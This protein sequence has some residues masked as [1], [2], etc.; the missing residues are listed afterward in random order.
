MQ[1]K[2]I[3][4]QKKNKKVPAGRQEK[5]DKVTDDPDNAELPYQNNV[6]T[7]GEEIINNNII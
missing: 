5:P 3:R 1:N 7:K 4:H 2:L 6:H